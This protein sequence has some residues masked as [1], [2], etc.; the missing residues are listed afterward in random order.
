MAIGTEEEL[1]AQCADVKMIAAAAAADFM[2]RRFL[3]IFTTVEHLIVGLGAKAKRA[4]F[5]IMLL[6]CNPV[7]I[8]GMIGA[9]L[10]QALIVLR[11]CRFEAVEHVHSYILAVAIGIHDHMNLGRIHAQRIS[12]FRENFSTVSANGAAVRFM[13]SEKIREIRIIFGL[14]K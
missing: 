1:L 9:R 2:P 7:G 11:K 10:L 13:F 8:V 4:A 12:H 3:H 14:P 6:F 5:N